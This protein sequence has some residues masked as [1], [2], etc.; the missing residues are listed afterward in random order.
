MVDKLVEECREHI[1]GKESH[2]N[3]MIYNSTINDY[4]KI[5]SSCECSSCAISLV[6]FVISFIISRS[7]NI[8]FSI[9]KGT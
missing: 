1:D 5:S 4:E 7:V 2:Q 6:L 8:V 9:F 3:K